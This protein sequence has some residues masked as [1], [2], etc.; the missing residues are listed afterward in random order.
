MTDHNHT[1]DTPCTLSSLPQTE[2][3]GGQ[4][5]AASCKLVMAPVAVLQRRRFDGCRC[6]FACDAAPFRSEQQPDHAC[7]GVALHTILAASVAGEGRGTLPRH[8]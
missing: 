1:G 8:H 6:A 7:S 4:A 3:A 5:C 2:G